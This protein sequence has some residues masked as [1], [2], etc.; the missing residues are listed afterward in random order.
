MHE[1]RHGRVTQHEP[2]PGRPRMACPASLAAWVCRQ[3]S[4]AALRELRHPRRPRK[5]LQREA[6]P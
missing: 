4:S 5:A 6:L 1:L 3:S 2:R